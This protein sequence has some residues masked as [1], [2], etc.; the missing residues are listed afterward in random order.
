MKVLGITLA[1]GGSK[2]VPGKHTRDLGGKPVIAWTVEAALASRY[3]DAYAVSS[4]S[5]AIL[6]AAAA[7]GCRSNINRPAVLAQDDTPT[8]PALVQAANV[9]EDQHRMKFDYIV[10]LRATA[11]FKTADD[12]DACIRLLDQSG[13]DSVI[14]VCRLD[15]HHPARIKWVNDD[16]YLR[17]WP[18]NPEPASGRRQDC[19]PLAYIRN[20]SIYALRREAVMERFGKIFGH[21]KSLPYFM[22]PLTSVNIDS[23][24][25]WLMCKAIVAERH[26]A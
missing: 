6:G 22:D 21:E 7:A 18:L 23:E 12:I 2:G 8:L 5:A 16:G 26:T 11:P 13:A 3:L 14:G 17:D 25:D 4:D 24:L 20:G 19:R 15:D 10:E 1:R 9:M